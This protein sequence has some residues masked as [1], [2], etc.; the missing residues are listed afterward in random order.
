VW[1]MDGQNVEVTYSRTGI[2]APLGSSPAPILPPYHLQRSGSVKPPTTSHAASSSDEPISEE[3]GQ[4]NTSSTKTIAVTEPASP[5]SNPI[6]S[7]VSQ[8]NEIA[9][10]RR[11]KNVVWDFIPGGYDHARIWEAK[12]SMD[13]AVVGTGAAVNKS[14][15]KSIAARE[16][17]E[18]LGWPFM[19]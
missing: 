14:T 1:N 7:Y 12:L 3:P 18:K 5:V 8:F 4:T 16:A 10:Q 2:M 17:L 13:G 19:P 6:K 9:A 11:E 15:A